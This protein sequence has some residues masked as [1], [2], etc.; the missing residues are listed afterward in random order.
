MIPSA[1]RTAQPVLLHCLATAVA[2][3]GQGRNGPE[4]CMLCHWIVYW[5]SLFAGVSVPDAVAMPTASA[6]G[7][8][9]PRS[10]IV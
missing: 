10:F 5:F 3:Q 4:S 6:Q 1:Q 8:S 9:D 7:L 2:K